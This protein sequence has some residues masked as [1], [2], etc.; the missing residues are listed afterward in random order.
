M[1]GKEKK[2]KEHEK[3]QAKAVNETESN[4]KA[5]SPPPYQLKADGDGNPTPPDG[6]GNPGKKGES[7]TPLPTS[8]KAGMEKLGGVNLGDVKVFRN[9]PKPAKLKAEAYARGTEI[10]LGPG[11]ERH[12]GHE[13]WHVVQQKQG[14][15]NPTMNG[16]GGIAINDAPNL[17]KEADIMG[18]KALSIKPDVGSLPDPKTAF[19]PGNFGMNCSGP[20]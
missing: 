17:E 12:L 13:A 15:V 2:T 3:I 18:A 19:K 11:M 10:H 8:I 16:E 7:P 20:A 1:S 9:S 4:A 6:D 14:R 5:L